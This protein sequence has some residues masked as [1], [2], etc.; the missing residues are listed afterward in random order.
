MKFFFV[1]AAVLS[2]HSS[3]AQT[4]PLA[5]SA[6]F[7]KKMQENTRSFSFDG[8]KPLGE[9]WDML[10]KQF[11]DNQFVAWGE[12]HNSPLLSQLAAYALAAASR[13]GFKNWCVE[14]SPFAATE[15]TGVAHSASPFDSLKAISRDHPGSATFPFFSTAE[16]A[17]MLSTASKYTYHIWGIDQEFQMAFPYCITK[18][19]NAQSPKI[20]KAYKAVYDSLLA[21]WWMPKVTL[22]DSLKKVTA[23]PDFKN[24]LEDIKISRTIYYNQD[25]QMR[26]TLMKRNFFSYY[27]KMKAP[28]QKVFF[29]LGANHLAKG[30]NL[31]TNLYDI[32][33][34]AYE[35]SQRNNTGFTNVYFVNRYYT[36]K[37]KIM[38]DLESNEPEYPKEFLQLYDKSK[39]IVVDVRPLRMRFNNDKTI[40]ENALSILYKYDF[41]VI[42]PEIMK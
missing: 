2:L 8:Q 35:L 18:V 26:A 4:T 42:S 31:M 16:D 14:V 32:G 40:S 33:N 25:N 28:D 1:V 6:K 11:A 10:E 7:N 36:D 12:Y 13:Y 9:G 29:K 5:D 20:K 38:D 30:L 41:V 27:D 37:G 15:L 34:A 3:L 22:L 17:A 19:Y 21:K 23:Q 24:A 39:W